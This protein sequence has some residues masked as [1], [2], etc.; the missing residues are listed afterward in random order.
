MCL[1]NLNVTKPIFPEISAI[2]KKYKREWFLWTLFSI[3]EI[4]LLNLL[5]SQITNEYSYFEDSYE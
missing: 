3:S 4:I 1:I 2:V 5:L